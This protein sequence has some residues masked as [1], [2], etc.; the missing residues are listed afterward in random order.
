MKKLSIVLLSIIFFQSHAFSNVLSFS[1]FAADGNMII[2]MVNCYVPS[3][4]GED[5]IV[6]IEAEESLYIN[7]VSETENLNIGTIK[8][9]ETASISS[10]IKDIIAYDEDSYISANNIEFNAKEGNIGSDDNKLKITDFELVSGYAKENI[11]IEIIT[12]DALNI[13]EDAIRHPELVSGSAVYNVGD[14]KSEEGYIDIY[15]GDSGINLKGEIE[16]KESINADIYGSISDDATN[17]TAGFYSKN[18]N[19]K[20]KTGKIGDKD[21]SIRVGDFPSSAI[22]GG[23]NRESTLNANA[24]SGIYI[25]SEDTII[26]DK[27]ET[28][29]SDVK[30]ESDNDIKAKKQDNEGSNIKAENIELTA[31]G[32]IG[33]EDN[34]IVTEIT[35]EKGKTNLKANGNIY[36]KQ[37]G[38]NRFY[39][40]YVINK[41]NGNTSLLLPDNHAFII[42]LDIANPGLFRIDFA[43]RKYKNNISIGHNSIEKLA[44]H[45]V[46]VRQNTEEEEEKENKYELLK[47]FQ[48]NIIVHPDLFSPLK[49]FNVTILKPISKLKE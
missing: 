41:G 1:L 24:E 4:T 10:E 19:L 16:A 42:D 40:D 5:S 12:P 20:S 30:L 32:N 34:R 33:E 13:E 48:D 38:M 43:E 47:G 44:I 31:G 49:Q 21:N 27:V 18:V 22:P 46:A 23:S 26:A 36:L 39:S 17:N 11:N 15:S 6:N 8:A 28:E 3:T 9:G 35:K 14:L 7:N 2:K 25:E 37:N 45:P 29:K